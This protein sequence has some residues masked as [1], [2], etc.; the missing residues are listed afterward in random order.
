[1]NSK[2]Y[3]SAIRIKLN[4]ELIER[5]S[6]AAPGF[7]MA[8]AWVTYHHFESINFRST[9]IVLGICLMIIASI[10]YIIRELNKR[11]FLSVEIAADLLKVNIVANAV[12]WS[13]ALILP[14]IE[15]ELQNVVSSINII[16]LMLGLTLTSIVTLTQY[17]YIAYVYQG[18]ML[19]PS[20]LYLFYLGLFRSNLQA[21]HIGVIFLIGIIYI[22]KQTRDVHYDTL[23]RLKYSLELESTNKLLNESQMLLIKETAKLQHSTRLATLGEISGELAHEIN[24]PLGIVRGNIELSLMSIESDT[25]KIEYIKTKLEKSISSINRISKIIKGLRYLSRQTENEPYLETTTNEILHETL[26]FCS[27][28][29]NFNKIE[30]AIDSLA[31]YKINCRS[32]EI[33]QVLLNIFTNAIDALSKTT[34]DK[35]KIKIKVQKVDSYVQIAVSNS[36]EKIPAAIEDKLFQSFFSTKEVGKGMGLGL[37]ISKSI[38]EAHK[39]RLYYDS[40]YPQ[41]TFIIEL[42]ILT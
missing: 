11:G 26:D 28:K 1:M 34:Y 9:I 32:I 22:L 6:A 4:E 40:K 36:G 30:V 18:I 35:R 27:E 3:S 7:F 38:I 8:A 16:A 19:V 20:I 31:D 41:T 37:S 29:F 14:M 2:K 33:S 10:R 25:F 5:S 21:F 13:T 24:N 23:K 39:G 17:L 12:L 15:L 42:P